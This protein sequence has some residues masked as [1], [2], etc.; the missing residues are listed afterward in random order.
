VDFTVGVRTKVQQGET[1]ERGDTLFEVIS[2]NKRKCE[3][4][5]QR[6]DQAVRIS[7]S[8]EK[9]GPLILDVVGE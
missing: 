7:D 4:A 3:Q 1:I 9:P 8:S 2:N 6:L 5:L